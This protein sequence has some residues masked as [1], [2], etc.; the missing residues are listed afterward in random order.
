MLQGRA[1]T[2]SGF[3]GSGSSPKSE[4]NLQWTRAKDLAC[5]VACFL[6]AFYWRRIFFVVE[7]GGCRNIRPLRKLH[8]P[9]PIDLN[10]WENERDLKKY[11]LWPAYDLY[12]FCTTRHFD[13]KVSKKKQKK[14]LADLCQLRPFSAHSVSDFKEVFKDKVLYESLV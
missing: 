2:T 14:N 6:P 12:L 11:C 4:W 9:Y 13:W 1:D 5:I 3:R 7:R 8:P 10:A